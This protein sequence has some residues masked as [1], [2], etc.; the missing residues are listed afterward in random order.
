MNRRRFFQST[1]AACAGFAW[2]NSVRA[3]SD[4]HSPK[5]WRT[6]EVTTKVEVLK[7]SGVTRIWVPAALIRDTSF[8]RMLA[9]R[10]Q[11]ETGTVK[12]ITN[13]QNAL[14]IVLA[15]YAPPPQPGAHVGQPRHGERLQR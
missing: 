12:F 6:F 5:G 3:R 7:P 10:Y 2:A 8:Q 14:G 11:A 4:T 1:G 9:N 15:S 13:K